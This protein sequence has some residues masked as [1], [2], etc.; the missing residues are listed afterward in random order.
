MFEDS[1]LYRAYERDP[2]G[3]TLAVERQARAVQ[4]RRMARAVLAGLA[5]LFGRKPSPYRETALVAYDDLDRLLAENDNAL[6]AQG[7]T[8]TDLEAFRDG[9]VFFL[10]RRTA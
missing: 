2:A 5:R 1:P 4:G 3:F 6:A 10:Q 7:L 8:R 9:R